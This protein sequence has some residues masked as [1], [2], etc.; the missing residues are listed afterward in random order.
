MRD[1]GLLESG[2]DDKNRLAAF[3][4][5]SLISIMLF[6]TVKCQL[7][8]VDTMFLSLFLNHGYGPRFTVTA[9]KTYENFQGA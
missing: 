6:S 4:P 2:C 3:F 8:Q 1:F 9:R 5:S 7:W